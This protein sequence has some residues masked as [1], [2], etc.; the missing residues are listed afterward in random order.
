MRYI[1]AADVL[2]EELLRE[3]QRYADGAYLYIPRISENRLSWG[4]RTR[5]KEET[6]QRNRDIYARFQAGEGPR[7]LAG[8]YFLTEKTVRRIILAQR[9]ARGGGDGSGE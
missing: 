3:V 5:S 1:K 7:E 9:K 4:D 8:A 2:P 6:A